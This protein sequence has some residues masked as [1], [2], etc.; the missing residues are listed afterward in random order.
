[1]VLASEKYFQP[2]WIPLERV[3]MAAPTWRSGRKLLTEIRQWSALHPYWTLT[4]VVLAA[5]VPFLGKPFNMDDPLFIWVARQIHVHPA[6]PYGFQSNWFGT[7]LPTWENLWDPPLACYYLAAAAA[8][9][10][11]SEVALHAAFLLPALA[12]ILG[13]YRLAHHLCKHPMLAALATLFTPVFLISSTT[14]MCDV[15]MVSFWVWAVV[16]WVEGIERDNP[17]QLAGAALLV[18][19]AAMTK[20]FGISLIPL[21]AVYSMISK[22]R[23]GRWVPCLLI[24][25]VMLMLY[26]WIT[27]LLYGRGLLFD[28]GHH[29]TAFK[30]THGYT[31][32][33]AGFTSLTFTG[34]C[35]AGAMFFAPVLWRMRVLAGFA[36]GAILLA[37]PLFLSGALFKKYAMIQAVS[38]PTV[39]VQ[40][41]IWAFGGVCVLALPVANILCARDPRSWLLLLWVFGTFLFTSLFNWDVNSR[42]ILPM[43]PAVGILLARRWERN[44]AA[45]EPTR[46]WAVPVCLAVGALFALLVARAD[47]LL[48]TAVRQCAQQT[49]LRYTHQQKALWFQGHWG[50]QYYMEAFGASALD[51]ARSPL[52]PGDALAVPVNNTSLFP[53]RPEAVKSQEILTISGPNLL[54]TMNQPMGAGFYA[55]LWGPLPFVFGRVPPEVVHVYV[56]GPVPPAPAPRTK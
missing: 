16:L 43:A 37:A 14:V 2:A 22:G 1:M 55:S 50:F 15:L 41:V 49:C 53:P 32:S 13:T 44:P 33:A 19:L 39:E 54:T 45:N 17:W 35:L 9:L 12:L 11:W 24:P 56:L 8:L 51:F 40:I 7:D 5:L 42:S 29:A 6:N 30:E 26:Q 38:W 25:L 28:A 21:L 3:D 10:G 36:A 31:I 48:A 47:F 52:K 23:S 20:H 27:D 18:T 4:L 46:T 34:G